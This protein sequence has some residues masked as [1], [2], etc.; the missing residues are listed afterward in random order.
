MRVSITR[1]SCLYWIGCRHAGKLCGQAIRGD[2]EEAERVTEFHWPVRVYYEDTDSGGVVYYANYLKFMER[3]RTEWLRSLGFEQDRL[4]SELGLIFA[5][6]EVDMRY[7][8]QGYEIRVALGAG[9][10]T[11]ESFKVLEQRFEE[12]YIRFY[13]VLCEGVPIQAVNWRVVVSGPALEIEGRALKVGSESVKTDQ[14]YGGRSV[15]FRPDEGAMQTPVYRRESLSSSFHIV[16][17]AIIEE[18]ESTSIV[19]PGWSV[20]VD[21]NGCLV[22]MRS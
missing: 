19:L 15:M 9:D 2:R 3:A 1:N 13:G 16:G 12:E 22:L 14:P 7:L 11:E 20:R 4:A 8:R 10:V 6:T 18:A 21:E 5:V 17:P